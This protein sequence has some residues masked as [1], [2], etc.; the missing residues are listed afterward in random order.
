MRSNVQWGRKP[1]SAT[2][3]TIFAQAILPR[4]D[5]LVAFSFAEG[6]YGQVFEIPIGQS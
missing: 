3:F 6:R 2:R 5:L 4:H 1:S